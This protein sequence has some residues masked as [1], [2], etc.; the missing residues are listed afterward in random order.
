MLRMKP[1]LTSKPVAVSESLQRSTTSAAFATSL[2]MVLVATFVTLGLILDS[3]AKIGSTL[4]P[5]NCPWVRNKS[6][7]PC[8]RLAHHLAQAR[9]ETAQPGDHQS[10]SNIGT[11][12]QGRRRSAIREVNLGDYRCFA[13]PR[14]L[15]PFLG[16]T[17]TLC[18][19]WCPRRDLNS[20]PTD[21]K[22]V[23]LPTELQGQRAAI[24]IIV[25][26]VK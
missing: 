25:G 11:E 19:Y 10:R 6:N 4:V 16:K 26:T 2:P 8:L 3:T 1:S 23:A 24:S 9:V 18:L 15:C 12:G 17:L 13:V 21:Y 14:R 22:S 7:R 5:L 20:R